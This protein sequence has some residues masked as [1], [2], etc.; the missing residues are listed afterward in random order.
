MSDKESLTDFID[1][2]N[3]YRDSDGKKVIKSKDMEKALMIAID[4]GT[5]ETI[6][7]LVET[8]RISNKCI[9]NA[10]KL[11][12]KNSDKYD[13]LNSVLKNLNN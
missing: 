8:G 10:I 11:C 12:K 6:I 3:T 1:L 2:F 5:I 7:S 4:F 9:K 13:Y